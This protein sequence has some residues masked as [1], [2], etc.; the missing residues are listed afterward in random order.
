MSI[1]LISFYVFCIPLCYLFTFVYGRS[2]VVTTDYTETQSDI[3][4]DEERVGLGI[5]GLWIGF[6]IGLLHQVIRYLYLIHSASW[7]QAIEDA[8]ER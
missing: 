5:S 2:K 3:Y 1:N 7:E 4:L 8:K 6:S